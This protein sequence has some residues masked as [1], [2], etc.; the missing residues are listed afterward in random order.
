MR[1]ACTAHA[2]HAAHADADADAHAAAA[3]APSRGGCGGGCSVCSNRVARAIDTHE[4][5]RQA[6]H[7]AQLLCRLVEGGQVGGVP[8]MSCHVMV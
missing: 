2:A 7:T 8:V 5:R 4:K 1:I 6:A 3:L